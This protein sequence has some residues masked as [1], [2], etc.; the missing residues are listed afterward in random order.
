MRGCGYG[1]GCDG[2]LYPQLR[3]LGMC[4]DEF[5]L[6]HPSLLETSMCFLWFSENVGIPETKSRNYMSCNENLDSQL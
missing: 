1:C 6:H 5:P 3:W 4:K 2:L